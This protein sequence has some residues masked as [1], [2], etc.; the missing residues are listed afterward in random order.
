VVCWDLNTG[1]SEE[2]SVLLTA[3]P[4]LQPI[5]IHF[6]PSINDVLGLVGDKE[7]AA[8]GHEAKRICSA[9]IWRSHLCVPHHALRKC[10]GY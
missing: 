10:C 7:E 3:E 9:A 2:Q 5:H 4:S 1:P 6:Y 8:Q